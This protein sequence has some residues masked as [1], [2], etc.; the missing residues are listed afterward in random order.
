MYIGITVDL[1]N[2]GGETFDIRISDFLT[3]KKV[4]EITWQIKKV[5]GIPSEGFW[6][7]VSNKEKV[8]SGYESLVNSG[9]T[10]GD[11]IEIL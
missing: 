3:I 10:N 7:R 6:V 2:Y 5:Q 9:I 1:K 4:V 8:C 11:R